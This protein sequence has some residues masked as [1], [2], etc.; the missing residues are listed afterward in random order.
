VLFSFYKK[1]SLEIFR[2][3]DVGMISNDIKVQPVKYA[4]STLLILL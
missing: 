2:F 1:R 4:H 3:L